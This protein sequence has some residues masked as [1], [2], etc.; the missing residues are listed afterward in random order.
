MSR[1]ATIAFCAL[2]PIGAAVAAAQ[3]PG[4]DTA[5]PAAEMQR[6]Y[7]AAKTPYK[8]GIVLRPEP[9]SV[10]D[11][12]SV[13][14][15]GDKW[16]MLYVSIKDKVG[17]ETHIAESDNLLDWKPMGTVLPFSG[18]G[19]DMWQADGGASL[20][21]PEWGGSAEIRPYAGRYWQ[22][23]IGGAKQGY[24]TD[25]LSIGAA[26]T[27]A[28]D[29]AS[30]WNRLPENPVLAPGQPDARPFERAT[31]FKSHVL[32]DEGQ[33]LGYPFVM[34]YNAKQAGPWVERIGMAVSRDMVHWSRYGTGPVIDNGR[35]ISGDPQVVRM[36]DLWVMFYFGA[37]WQ[38]PGP[39][40]FDTFACSRDLVHWTLW[41]GRDLIEPSEAWD[42]TYAHKPWLL[43]W[44]G[45][46]YHFYCAVGSEGRA[47]AVATS[48]DMRPGRASDEVVR[49]DAPA[50]H[51]T[52][53]SPI[54]NGR[55]GAMDCGGVSEERLILNESGMWSGSRQDAD[56]TDAAAALPE[57][58][59]LLLA[60]KNAEAEKLVNLRFTCAGLG[61]GLG[62]GANIPYGSYQVLGNLRLRFADSATPSTG[63]RRELDLSEAVERTSFERA[64][65]HFEREAFAS[66]PD[67]VIAVRLSADHPGSI[68]F[69]ATLDRP[70][71]A[72]T[73]SDS[74][75]G[76]VMSG[77][78][79]NG[80]DGNGVRF[81]A[82]V[83]AQVRGGTSA[84]AD[85]VL[86]VR[87][88]DEVV[89]LVAAATDIR[90]FAGRASDD[91][92]AAAE[93]DLAAASAKTYGELRSAHVADYRGYYD[94]VALH[95]GPADSAQSRAPL[96]TPDRLRAF[97][98]GGN[99]L[100]LVALYFNFGRYLLI[101]TS[102]PGGLPPNL[103]GLWAEGIQTPWNGDWH[104]NVNVQMNY[105]PAETCN[106]SD[107]HKPLFDLIA[108]LQEPGAKTARDYYG[109]R[110]WVAHVITNPWGFTSPG[111]SA[112]WGS[113]TTGSAWLCQH[114]W[115]HFEFTGDRAFLAWAYPIM[116][117]SALFYVDQLIEEPKHG[118]LVTA[119]SNSPENSFL[120][121][122]G[123]KVHLCMG[124][125]SDMQLVR[126]LFGSCIA[127]SRIL[128]VDSDLRAELEAKR[129]RL[130]PTRVGSD[131][132]VMEW[133]EEY[134]EPEPHHRHVA[135]L[136]GLYPGEEITPGATPALAAAARKTLDA[137]GDASTGWSLAFK[138][139]LWARLGDGNR[140]FRILHEGLEPTTMARVGDVFSGGTYP[141]LFDAH[142]PFQIDGNFGGT[143]GI[144][145]MLLQSTAAASDSSIE[146]ATG[147]VPTINLLPALP[148][149]WAEGSVRGLRAR[150]NLEVSIT[151]SAGH[152]QS[153]TV[154]NTGGSVATPHVR[155]GS[156]GADLS[157][158]PG[159]IVSLDGALRRL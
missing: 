92:S 89:L 71:R 80:V 31:L 8:Y 61:S 115:D 159:E 101:S 113:T 39:R 3:T 127:A 67:Q 5:V 17:Y 124:S 56:R 150:G 14:R 99:D 78:L 13:F 52:E 97:R 20:V 27:T 4:A 45:V 73:A 146:R 40:A 24:E 19:W 69:D 157:L 12:P 147:A 149:A 68:S 129:A 144:A 21:D 137:R 43:K 42:A 64:G 34:F 74:A 88:A 7:E 90:T 114:L 130:A 66:A 47:I 121:A 131:G 120:M 145:E 94:R 10:V 29:V 119:P 91:P 60:G 107:L 33:T 51:F 58:R 79:N 86:H 1:A 18:S 85:G 112:T 54:G 35:G 111:E 49:L 38:K 96:A 62:R 154:R 155:C 83:R 153:A 63:Y 36:G 138:L 22:T 128:G 53:S 77:R 133:L 156:L 37:G 136:W 93:A 75:G 59:R 134:V 110:G 76:L 116:K 95:L 108:S 152:L 25:P 143:A 72:T 57:I 50:S 148:D 44:R 65:V 125:T 41:R 118:W 81:A 9:G 23:Y 82:A 117:G 109:A 32:W 28:P 141:N 126:N 6:V 104:L 151:W 48:V 103:Q 158:K 102:R 70:E 11:C 105:W 87:G 123:T 135:H 30:P 100:S 139:C 140:A 106:L 2:V 132:R 46:V 55:L 142:P 16:Y 26:W 84:C 122:D 98:E 15:H